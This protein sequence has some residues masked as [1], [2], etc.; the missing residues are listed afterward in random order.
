MRRS[1][2]IGTGT[3]HTKTPRLYED[4]GLLTAD[5]TVGEDITDLVNHLTGYSR[6][7]EYRRLLVAP[8]GLRSWLVERIEAQEGRA[9]DVRAA[10]MPRRWHSVLDGVVIQSVYRRS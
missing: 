3:Y 7:T 2:N 8:A 4:F 6:K 9:G 10:G 5:P 1:C